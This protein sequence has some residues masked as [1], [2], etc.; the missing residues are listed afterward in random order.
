MAPKYFKHFFVKVVLIINYKALWGE[1]WT[2]F[3]L[4]DPFNRTLW[5]FLL[6]SHKRDNLF[7]LEFVSHL[8]VLLCLW[9]ALPQGQGV[10][11]YDW[12][13]VMFVRLAGVK[14]GLSMY[15]LNG[16]TG[17]S[18]QSQLDNLS[19][20][21]TWHVSLLSISIAPSST[22][23]TEQ[24]KSVWNSFPDVILSLQPRVTML[25]LLRTSMPTDLLQVQ[26]RWNW[27]RQPYHKHD[28]TDGSSTDVWRYS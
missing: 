16:D 2:V 9:A 14:V 22:T 15:R 18:W 1:I 25:K 8:K 10:W 28:E 13:L 11:L 3:L 19:A 6:V 4:E 26:T 20:A 27:R 5:F 24:Q 17:H 7:I 23:T 21:L 12:P